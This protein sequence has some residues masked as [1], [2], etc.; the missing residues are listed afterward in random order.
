MPSH[1]DGEGAGRVVF[2]ATA[3]EGSGTAQLERA[4]VCRRIGARGGG[5]GG[6]GNVLSGKV[7]VVVVVFFIGC[8]IFPCY[9]R[10]RVTARGGGGV[11]I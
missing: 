10:S 5:G 8:G 4:S 1:V 7:V 9:C 6:S 2:V 11:I 3:A